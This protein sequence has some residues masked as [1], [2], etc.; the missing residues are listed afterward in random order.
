M[1]GFV[2]IL[3]CVEGSSSINAPFDCFAL[4]ER[5]FELQLRF[6]K[7]ENQKR[8]TKQISPHTRC[9]SLGI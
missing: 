7:T 5:R 3:L 4:R 1:K 2:Y 9:L 6:A 8:S